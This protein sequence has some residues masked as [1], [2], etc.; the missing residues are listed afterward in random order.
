LS[1]VNGGG[2]SQWVLT[3]QV[4][5]GEMKG[6]FFSFRVVASNIEVDQELFGEWTH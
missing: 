2:Q 3:A 6:L 1:L 4:C 5:C